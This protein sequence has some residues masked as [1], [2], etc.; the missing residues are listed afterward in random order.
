MYSMKRWPPGRVTPADS[1]HQTSLPQ[2]IQHHHLRKGGRILG[3]KT[4]TDSLDLWNRE[5][6]FRPPISGCRV[7]G[8]LV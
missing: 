3:S 2:P 8:S 7:A 1:P 6:G 5:K 4:L